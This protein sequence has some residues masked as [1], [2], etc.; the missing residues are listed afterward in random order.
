MYSRNELYVYQLVVW[1]LVCIAMTEHRANTT[2]QTSVV[3]KLTSLTNKGVMMN[4][5]RSFPESRGKVIQTAKGIK[6]ISSWSSM[7]SSSL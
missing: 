6:L 3:R 4:N 2:L 1:K 5:T 7:D